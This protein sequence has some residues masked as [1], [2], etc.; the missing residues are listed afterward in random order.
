MLTTQFL[1]DASRERT[2]KHERRSVFLRVRVCR[3]TEIQAQ[4]DG[5]KTQQSVFLLFRD[6]LE[7]K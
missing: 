2:V 7:F 5:M 1:T 4:L 6:L 3:M